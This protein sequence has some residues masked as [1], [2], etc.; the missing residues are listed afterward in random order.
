MKLRD[1]SPHPQD[2]NFYWPPLWTGAQEKGRDTVTGEIGTLQYVYANNAT[3]TKYYLVTHSGGEF[4][5]GSLCFSHQSLSKKVFSLLRNNIGRTI[6]EIGN[7][8]I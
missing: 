7:L 2:K 3:W 5:V 4:Y 1:C 8:E 6:K